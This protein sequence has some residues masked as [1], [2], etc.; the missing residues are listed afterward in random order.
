MIKELMK[1]IKNRNKKKSINITLGV[2]IGYILTGG[3]VY[4]EEIPLK[5]K[6]IYDEEIKWLWPFEKGSGNTGGEELPSEPEVIPPKKDEIPWEHDP[7][8]IVEWIT[9]NKVDKK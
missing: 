7:D 8:G 9:V 2:I 1:E 3:I 5:K 4:S 6:V